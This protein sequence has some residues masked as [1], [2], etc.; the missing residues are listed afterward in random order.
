MNTF[1]RIA[2]PR[3][4]A[5]ALYLQGKEIMVLPTSVKVEAIGTFRP[6]FLKRVLPSQAFP[7][8]TV[9]NYRQAYKGHGPLSYY[10]APQQVYVRR[11][12]NGFF[13]LDAQTGIETFF[14]NPSDRLLVRYLNANLIQVINSGYLLPEIRAKLRI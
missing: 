12:G 9:K 1:P 6:L 3:S 7:F 8:E 2:V 10:V 11:T 4:Q 14:K 13:L 5:Q